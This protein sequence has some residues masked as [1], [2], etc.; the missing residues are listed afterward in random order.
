MKTLDYSNLHGRSLFIDKFV[1]VVTGLIVVVACYMQIVVSF[2][3]W[4]Y[5]HNVLWPSF[6]GH[7]LGFA[8]EKFLSLVGLGMI[9]PMLVIVRDNNPRFKIAATVGFILNLLL[10]A[11]HQMLG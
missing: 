4:E 11:L 9:L 6:Y 1:L 7:L 8:Q 5:Y 10:A 3:S 2:W